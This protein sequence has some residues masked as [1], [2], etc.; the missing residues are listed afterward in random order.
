MRNKTDCDKKANCQG[1]QICNRC[2]VYLL[3]NKFKKKRD[4]TYQVVCKKCNQR[5]TILRNKRRCLHGKTRSQCK[6]CGGSGICEH[7]K[8]KSSCKECGGSQICKHQKF[9]SHCK[10]CDGASICA[11][12]KERIKCK[13][14]GGSQ[15]CEHDRIKSKCKDCGG[16]SICEHKKIRTMCKDCGGGSI[17]EHEKRRSLCKECGGGGICEH[18]KIRSRCKECDGGSICEHMKR[19]DNCK[20]CDF[21]NY[22][23]HIVSNKCK[24]A[25][26]NNKTQSSIE[27]LG[28]DIIIYKLYIEGQ[29]HPE[30]SWDNYGEWEIDHIIPVK[31]KKPTIEQQIVRLHYTNTQPL[32]KDE[33]MRK[34]NKLIYGVLYDHDFHTEFKD[35]K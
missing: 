16:G 11:H 31:Y 10:E 3:F 7:Q 2:K 6:E 32:W 21:G 1:K 30:M 14:C 13:E 18:D 9:K 23:R 8:Y 27:Y 20:Y 24:Q 29:F 26:K 28:C 12:K 33:N 19:R 25:L 34:S 17:C 4:D 22:L 35:C 15:I 5:E